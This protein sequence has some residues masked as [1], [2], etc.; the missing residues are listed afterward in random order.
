M[1]KLERMF[2]SSVN[3]LTL[4]LVWRPQGRSR[5]AALVTEHLPTVPGHPGH[6]PGRPV[7]GPGVHGGLLLGAG[8]S[9]KLA[10][11]V[12]VG[13][14]QCL[15]HPELSLSKPYARCVLPIHLQF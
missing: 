4:L 15:I 14:A 10:D 11:P 9:A 7:V 2:C 6:Q 3:T 5:G 1:S 12:V 13:D 8:E